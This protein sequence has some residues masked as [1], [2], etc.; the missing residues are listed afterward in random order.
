MAYP[1]NYNNNTPYNAGPVSNINLLYQ[2]R[3]KLLRHNLIPITRIISTPLALVD[4]LTNANW[5][6]GVMQDWVYGITVTSGSQL[7]LTDGDIVALTGQTDSTQNGIFKYV[8]GAAGA[9][10]A[11]TLYV[12]KPAVLTTGSTGPAFIRIATLYSGSAFPLG[13]EAAATSY[14]AAQNY[15]NELWNPTT[16]FGVTGAL[17]QGPSGRKMFLDIAGNAYPQGF[18]ATSGSPTDNYSAGTSNVGKVVYFK[19]R[20]TITLGTTNIDV[21]SPQSLD[22]TTTPSS[23]TTA[24]TSRL[25]YNSDT[26]FDFFVNASA[27]SDILTNITNFF[28]AANGELALN[29][30]K[31]AYLAALDHRVLTQMKMK[32][33]ALLPDLFQFYYNLWNLRYVYFGTTGPKYPSE[34]NR[35]FQIYNSGNY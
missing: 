7:N 13:G 10:Y 15:L 11:K 23:Y 31:R 35:G 2:V 12:G 26:V 3:D 22:F 21:S 6:V 1:S 25:Q 24:G 16:R 17:A 27:L 5:A 14:T 28:D 33:A 34:Y 4:Y 8:Q 29:T 30:N 19:Q 18:Y 32:F 9:G 20:D